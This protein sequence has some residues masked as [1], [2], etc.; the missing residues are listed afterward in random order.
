MQISKLLLVAGSASLMGLAIPSPANATWCW[1]KCGG[2]SGGGT[3]SGGSSGGTPTPVPEPEQMALFGM[4]AA[5]LA[6]RV[7][8]A[9][10]KQK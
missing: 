7:F 4:G 6:G 1:F 9:R 5:V 10:R 3:S 2:S 8:F